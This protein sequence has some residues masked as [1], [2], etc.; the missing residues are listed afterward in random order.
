MINGYM[1]IDGPRLH[2]YRTE[3]RICD[4]SFNFH[5]Y[6]HTL[7]KS[8]SVKV[9]LK[10]QR[11]K[12]LFFPYKNKTNLTVHSRIHL[13]NATFALENLGRIE[14]KKWTRKLR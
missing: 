2:C 12:K 1:F 7:F 5:P 8:I 14:R 10:K 3:F 11:R 4:L 9:L 13:Q 6:V